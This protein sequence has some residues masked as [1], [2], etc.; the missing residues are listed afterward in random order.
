LAGLLLRTIVTALFKRVLTD[1]TMS[2]RG[3]PKQ[4]VVNLSINEVQGMLQASTMQTD[5]QMVRELEKKGWTLH[6]P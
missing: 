4:N 2:W 5:A 1:E 3:K 6:K